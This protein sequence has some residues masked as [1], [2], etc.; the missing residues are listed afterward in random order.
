MDSRDKFPNAQLAVDEFVRLLQGSGSR[1][2]LIRFDSQAVIVTSLRPPSFPFYNPGSLN[3]RGRTALLDAVELGVDTLE[4]LGDPAHIWAIVAF[5][6]GQENAS[7]VTLAATE[8]HLRRIP[9][10]RFYG[11]AYG[12]D[13]DLGQLSVLAA[14]GNGIA[15]RSD[16]A[17]IRAVYERLS[18]YV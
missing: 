3:P 18:T 7:N 16:P 10:I 13:A 6:D 2:C 4:S 9:K 5:T 17:T 12:A 8:Q 14:A 1:A 15:S 11:I